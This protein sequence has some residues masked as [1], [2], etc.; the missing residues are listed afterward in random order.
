MLTWAVPVETKQVYTKYRLVPP[1]RKKKRTGG[2]WL[3]V[4]VG[5]G[6]LG[7]LISQSGKFPPFEPGQKPTPGPRPGPAQTNALAPTAKTPAGVSLPDTART[8][9]AAP[10]RRFKPRP[11]Q[12]VLEAQ[13]ALLRRGISCGSIDGVLGSQT[14]AALRVYQ[15]Q[16]ALPVSGELDPAT[17]MRL[18]LEE[19]PYMFYTITANDFTRLLPVAR[20]WLGKSDQDRLDFENILELVSEQARTHPNL[21]RRLNPAVD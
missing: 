5:L 14:R 1:K 2:N 19:T 11:V 6:M 4:L 8:N 20:T 12:D 7:W 10:P 15:Q 16:M 3:L 17:R 21:I 9:L 18:L 13:L